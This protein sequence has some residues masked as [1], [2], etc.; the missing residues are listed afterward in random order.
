[1]K[2]SK[3]SGLTPGR[4]HRDV[5]RAAGLTVSVQDTV[6]SSIAFAGI[7]HLGATVPP[8]L[9]RCVLNCE[10]MVT[11]KTAEF[12]ARYTGGGILPSASPGLG[13]TVDEAVLGEPCMTWE[14]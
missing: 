12:D 13:L 3:V 4:R 11:L 9:L 5:C 7:V 8:R 10:E 6:G 2:I 1:M 14:D